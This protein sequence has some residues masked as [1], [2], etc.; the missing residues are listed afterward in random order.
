MLIW[1]V[2]SVNHNVITLAIIQLVDTQRPEGTAVSAHGVQHLSLEVILLF[3]QPFHTTVTDQE[4]VT[5]RN[6]S[7]DLR[8]GSQTAIALCWGILPTR[9]CRPSI[10]CAISLSSVP[11]LI[12]L[13]GND[14]LPSKYKIIIWFIF[15]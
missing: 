14:N 1:I 6:V 3:D 7:I 13:F 15:I 10:G 12:Y 11:V 4:V 8:W 2:L 5:H 9:S